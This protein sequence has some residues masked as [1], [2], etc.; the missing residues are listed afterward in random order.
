MSITEKD[1]IYNEVIPFL[2]SH[3]HMCIN[4]KIDRI[5]GSSGFLSG[6]LSKYY[7][8]NSNKSNSWVGSSY[9]DEFIQEIDLLSVKNNILYVSE[10]K[11]VL[12]QKHL[13]QAIGQIILHKYALIY[14][15]DIEIRYYIIFPKVSYKKLEYCSNEVFNDIFKKLM[16]DSDYNNFRYLSDNF[17]MFMEKA[18]NIEFLMI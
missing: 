9:C 7:S 16:N 14:V 1:F 3:G 5:H 8:T 15:H 12:N 13:Q 17:T 10:V 6:K 11:S 2:E 18:F 4:P